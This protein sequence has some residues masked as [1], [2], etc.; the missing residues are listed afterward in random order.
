MP[1]T[2]RPLKRWP[3]WR[4][5]L[6]RLLASVL[7][8]GF[9]LL[10]D[11]E[12]FNIEYAN[13]FP[14]GT[15][16]I[17]CM[18]HRSHLDTFALA[19]EVF[20]PR[21]R[22]RYAALM[23]SGKAMQQNFFQSLVKYVGAFPVSKDNPKPAIKY[24][25]QSLKEGFSVLVA[26]QGK[27]I[28]STPVHDYYHLVKE[29]KTGVGRIVLA[30]NGKIPV[31]PIYVHGTS[32]ALKVGNILPKFGWYIAISFGEPLFFHQ[33]ARQGGWS[34]QQPDYFIKAREIVDQVM[35]AIREQLLEIEKYY[36]QY[37]GWKL[38]V[39]MSEL[40]SLLEEAKRI[41]RLSRKLTFVPPKRLREYLKSKQSLDIK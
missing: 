6:Y 17:F 38:Q 13:Q 2:H 8:R 32:T 27:R 26:P 24:A 28:D 19:S 35:T 36:Y 41:K 29:G 18:N 4:R 37:L 23:G 9:R 22:R 40:E 1:K 10:F 25:V 12:S 33:Y 11:F 20:E 3:F 16:V 14:E 21:I 39:P 30:M 5:A 34:E 31:L 7:T 15:P